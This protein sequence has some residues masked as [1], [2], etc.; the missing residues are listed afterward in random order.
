MSDVPSRINKDMV[1]EELCSIYPP[2]WIRKTAK[3]TGL[4][5]RERKIDPVIMLWILALGYGVQL[6]HTLAA[7]KRAYEKGA[8]GKIR[9]SSWYD[10]FTP[11]LVAFLKACIMRGI[12][13]L[14]KDASRTLNHRLES[15]EDVLIQDSTII[16]LHEK[17]AKKWPAARAKKLA[18]GVKV[19]TL[20]SAIANGPKNISLF[21]ER[22]N[23]LKTLRIGPWIKDR[24][25]LID[26]GFYKYQL[27]TR[28]QEY[29]GFFVS[30]LKSNAN[31]QIVSDN[32]SQSRGKIDVKGVFLQDILPKLSGETLDVDID[33]SFKRRNYK[34]KQKK[35]SEKFRLVAVYNA[36][37]D[38]YHLYITNISREI[39]DADEIA[40]LYRGRWEVELIFKELKSRYKLDAIETTN[41]QVI[42]S[43]IWAAIL[44]L[45]ISRFIYNILRRLNP[46]KKMVRYTQLRWSTIFAE[47]SGNILTDVLR[48]LGIERTF[49][50]D[51]DVFQSQAL[52][53][54]VNRMR[55]REDLW[56]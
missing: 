10:R 9:D 48:Y 11:E 26:L 1:S 50:T 53:P 35:D 44:T 25:L 3:E 20:I 7:L 36:E 27:F 37:D 24:I 17:L 56:S 23:E 18:A 15:F 38:E 34:G 47:H 54:H 55:F 16:R 12:E 45:L 31:P 49:M 6:Q 22:T 46:D 13:H 32:R 40:K 19:A 30:R 2:E 14:G 51:Y 43:F 21:A 41:S 52:D 33:V 5:K 29:G 4:I 28:I 8:E 42:E 39:L